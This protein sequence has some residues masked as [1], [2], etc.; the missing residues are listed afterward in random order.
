M[1]FASIRGGLYLPKPPANFASN[2]PGFSTVATLTASTHKGAFIFRVPKTGTTKAVGFRLGTV[3]TPQDLRI[4]F[5]DVSATTGDP[6]GTEDQTV[7]IASGSLVASG[8]NTTGTI[9]R[10]VTRG[11]LLAIV[12]QADSGTPNLQISC[13]QYGNGDVTEFPYAEAFTTAWGSRFGRA[14]SL[15][16]QYDDNS[17]E[18]IEGFV[19]PYSD[20][21][22]ISYNT[23]ST[24]DEYG[25]KFQ[26][27]FGCKVNG[28]WMSSDIDG[29]GDIILYD[30]DGTSVLATTSID[31]D[32]D[33]NGGRFYFGF[34]TEI[35]L[36]A[37]TY[38]RL[39]L[40]PTTTT[41]LAL[42][43]FEVASAALLDMCDLGQLAHLT[44]RADAGAWS[45]VTTQRPWMGVQISAIDIGGTSAEISTPFVGMLA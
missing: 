36:T 21:A 29:D 39:V 13:P 6:D 10:S 2:A 40:K 34:V 18:P 16:L 44:K 7:V 8:W 28:G 11:D 1:S 25:L 43:Y 17:Y 4:S 41:N 20:L 5:Q 35:T 32:Q 23:T 30:S 12:I 3:T 31:K 14:G 38:Y 42:R 9:T 22:A 45:D 27:P 37:N 33:A 26:L 24:S 15:S 19:Y